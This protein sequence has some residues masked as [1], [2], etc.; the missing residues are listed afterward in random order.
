MDCFIVS[1]ETVETV[2]R[3]AK[4]RRREKHH[5]YSPEPTGSQ[6]ARP[7]KRKRKHKS[8]EFIETTKTDGEPRPALKICVCTYLYSRYCH[9]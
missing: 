1:G 5:R 9:S 8:V 6:N 2:V 7:H 4:K 3:S